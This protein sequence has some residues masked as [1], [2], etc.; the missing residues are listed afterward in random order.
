VAVHRS[1]APGRDEE[2]TSDGQ[3][4]HAVSRIACAVAQARTVDEVV[5]LYLDEVRHLVPSQVVGADL[6][7]G[8]GLAPTSRA[9]G[10]SDGFL[11]LYEEVGRSVDPVLAA[12]LRSA[13]PQTSSEL[14]PLDAWLQGDLYREVLVLYQLRSSMQAPI[15]S[16]GRTIGTVTFADG[17]PAFFSA[18][19]RRPLAG[20]LGAVL[21]LAVTSVVQQDSVRRQRDQ[22]AA[23]LD[24]G[25]RPVV[26]SDSRTGWRSVNAAARQ[27]L[28][29][30]DPV[31]SDE[32]LDTLLGISRAMVARGSHD[33]EVVALGDGS[34]A[35]AVRTYT[36]G[37]DPALAVTVLEEVGA[38]DV[39]EFDHSALS[40]RE[41]QIATFVSHGMQNQQIA[42]HL[43]ISVHTVKQHLKSIHRK[44][45]VTTRVELARTVLLGPAQPALV[46]AG[47]AWDR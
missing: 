13:E 38:H 31:R 21:G 42:D 47:N 40:Y 1:A 7:R 32:L 12:V 5:A 11:E 9:L 24:V 30:R 18:P 36:P 27:L 33:R 4:A 43:V 35:I 39:V 25:D 34:A 29:R 3:V 37:T 2:T 19:D 16:G 44:L 15:L 17:D 46:V 8:A 14:M 22:L 28:A 41:R 45:G 26:V 6:H 20:A 23:A 10:V